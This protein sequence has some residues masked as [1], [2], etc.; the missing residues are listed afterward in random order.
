METS[1]VKNNIVQ[2]VLNKSCNFYLENIL[3][4]FCHEVNEV[5][6]VDLILKELLFIVIIILLILT[7]FIYCVSLG[8]GLYLKQE[9]SRLN[10]M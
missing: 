2:I 1:C 5:K 3:W 9:V 10:L 7:I 4:N 8:F 6:T